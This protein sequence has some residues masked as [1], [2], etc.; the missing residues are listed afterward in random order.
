MNVLLVEPTGS[1]HHFILY[2]RLVIL[3]LSKNNYNISLLTTKN[4][5]KEPSFLHIKQSS[6][7]IINIYFLN[8]HIFKKSNKIQ[9]LL[10]QFNCYFNL[11][12]AFKEASEK[13]KFDK[14]IFL[15][16]DYCDKIISILGSPFGKHEFSCIYVTLSFH[17]FKI[18]ISNF[19]FLDFLYKYI[20]NRIYK[21]STLKKIFII[22][23]TFFFYLKKY[24]LSNRYKKLVYLPDPVEI[25]NN[26]YNKS[27]FEAYKSTI[28]KF[29][30]L[31][32]GT[33]NFKKGIKQLFD[34]LLYN[35]N[36]NIQL[37]I[38]GRA[39]LETDNL[40]N[41]TIYK[42]LFTNKQIIYLNR[43]ILN[44]EEYEIFNSVDAVW[45]GYVDDFSGSSGVYHQAS[46]YGKPVISKESGYLGW[47]TR[48]N[49]NGVF[50]NP[51]SPLSVNESIMLLFTNKTLAFNLGINGLKFSKDHSSN[52]FQN[53]IINNI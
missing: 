3:E 49:N 2:L 32:Y 51:L 23:E 6:K 27:N 16:L 38:A 22:D 17:R 36:L 11:K 14:V 26:I 7:N 42:S 30:I 43:F 52:N 28:K 40:I 9:L 39:D 45:V 8:E 19:K 15:D 44:E 31:V 46:L 48:E 41:N 24:N 1:G 34:G 13:Q 50:C 37:L 5:I 29:T 4:A 25:S 47:I 10:H 20:F 35:N 33:L 18:G 53:L 12:K 21:I